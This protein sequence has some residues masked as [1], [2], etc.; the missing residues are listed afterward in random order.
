MALATTFTRAQV[1]VDSPPV[2]V[3]AH[4]GGGLPSISIVGLAETSVKESR[5]RVKGA[6]INSN[7]QY[8]RHRII[9]N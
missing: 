5:D 6:L 2:C 1:G 7:F 4:L 8:P 3:E 9:V